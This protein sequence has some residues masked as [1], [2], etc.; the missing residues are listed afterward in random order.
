MWASVA[1]T[2]VFILF[3]AGIATLILDDASFRIGPLFVK[4]RSAWRPFLWATLVLV[5]RN[6]FVPAP[7]SFVNV[8]RSAGG[9]LRVGDAQLFAGTASWTRRLGEFVLLCAGFALLTI[10]FTWPQARDM[11]AVPDIGDPLFNIWRIAWVNHQIIRDPL[12][13]FDANI[14]YPARYALTDSDSVIVPSLMVA[15]LSWLGVHQ[16]I[17]Y[18]VVMLMSFTLS[19]VTM[20]YLMRALTGRTDAALIAGGI[21]ALYPYRFEHYSHLEL[22][23]TM[24]MPLALL[25]LH[26]VLAT[27]R[28]RDGLLVGL[29]YAL[30]MLSALYYGMFF[31]TYLVVVG[32]AL[33]LGHGRPK[34]P[35]APLLA[36]GVLAA[37]MIAPVAAAYVA[38]RGL[39][40]EREI[41]VIQ[42]YSATPQDYLKAHDRSWTYQ[43]WSHG[44]NPERQIFPRLTPVVLSAVAV[45]P[46]LS[47]ARI[48]YTLGLALCFDA[49]LGYNGRI[50]PWFHDHVP[51][52][53]GMR[54]PARFSMLTGMTLTI[55]AGF[56]AA[57]VLR[58][59]PRAVAWVLT[60]ITAAA[61]CWEAIPN[62]PLETVWREPPAIY[63]SLRGTHS[64]LAEY[65]MP[66]ESIRSWYDTRYEYFST[67]HWQKLVNGNSG[68]APKSYEELLLA[69]QTF[70]SD[71]AIAYLKKVGV[72]HIGVHGAFYPPPEYAAVVAA[73]NNRPDIELV[74]SAPWE[75]NE[76]RLYR[77]KR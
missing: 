53:T 37:V 19:G 77:L 38:N 29:F 14:F 18:N 70:P 45:A 59:M 23:M 47:V 66:K 58:R 74:A 15:P 26:R 4:M 12:H 35:V 33:W 6:W 71:E 32:T 61:V 69:Q 55:L 7:P 46:P 25:A 41:G 49:S 22:Q 60:A 34:K 73:L 20:F 30:Q 3:L 48:A 50:Y 27:S 39:V 43:D 10:V 52:F 2:L 21:F 72:D 42:F 1:D 65:P 8:F 5:I 31:M 63:D 51:G 64:V 44:A 13:L 40:G 54:V 16:A 24:W 62:M 67:W 9:D 68:F 76:S 17:V 11:F 36:G 28:L 56:G 75:G 57:R